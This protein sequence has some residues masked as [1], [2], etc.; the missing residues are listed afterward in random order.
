MDN[1]IENLKKQMWKNGKMTFYAKLKGGEEL[2]FDEV[3]FEMAEKQLKE[4]GLGYTYLDTIP[5]K[6]TWA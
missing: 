1:Y 4:L 3:S 5:P 6:L 2:L